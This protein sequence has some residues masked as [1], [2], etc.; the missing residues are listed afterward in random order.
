MSRVWLVDRPPEAIERVLRHGLLRGR[1]AAER[2]HDLVALTLVKALF[3]A[4]PNH[5]AGIG[6]I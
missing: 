5:G 3:L 2:E 4:D 6:A 1:A